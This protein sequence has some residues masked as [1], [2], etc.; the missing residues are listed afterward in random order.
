MK[1]PTPPC[2]QD[3]RRIC[4]P[5]LFLEFPSLILWLT[6]H[7]QYNISSAIGHITWLASI[8]MLSFTTVTWYGCYC[9]MPSGYH[10]LYDTCPLLLSH[11]MD[12]TAWYYQDI[13]ICMTP[14]LYY[15][16]MIRMLLHDTIRISPPVWHLFFT[17]VTW[18]GCYCMI[19]SGYHHLYDT[20]P[21][22]LSHD[23]DATAR[24]YQ[25]ITTCWHLSF[26]AVT[27][28]GCYCMIIQDITTCMTPILDCC[29]MI[30]MLLHD[31][32]RASPPAYPNWLLS[33]DMIYTAR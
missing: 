3:K 28:Y 26:T 10:H 22:L 24:Y 14:I 27:R 8:L 33:H 2:I 15:C 21:L 13:T 30:W 17:T 7:V 4:E 20:Y 19:P 5:Q 16:H 25:D 18:Y 11:D 23:M 31:T 1:F 9:M 6:H 29:H 12:A 32:I